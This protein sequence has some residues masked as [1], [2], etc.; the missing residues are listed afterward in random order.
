MTTPVQRII[1]AI[2]ELSK[3]NWNTI[4]KFI[5]NTLNNSLKPDAFENVQKI[6]ELRLTS[7]KLDEDIHSLNGN[8]FSFDDISLIARNNTCF[9]IIYT[10]KD[11]SEDFTELV[12]FRL[13]QEEFGN[14]VTLGIDLGKINSLDKQQSYTFKCSNFFI[15][16]DDAKPICG[17]KSLYFINEKIVDKNTGEIKNISKSSITSLR[18]KRDSSTYQGQ[19][20]RRFLPL[21]RITEDN[22]N[23]IFGISGNT[24]TESKEV[25][26]LRESIEKINDELNKIKDKNKIKFEKSDSLLGEWLE[27][28]YLFSLDKKELENVDDD[29]YKGIKLTLQ[30]YKSSIFELVQNIIFHGGK[31]GLIYCVFDKKAN[32]SNYYKGKLI[33]NIGEYENNARFLRIGIFDFN[34]NGIVKTYNKEGIKLIDFFDPKTIATTELSHLEMRYAAR[35]GIKTFVKTISNHKGF[36]SVESCNNVSEQNTKDRLYTTYKDEVIDFCEETIENTN[37]THYE[38]I[39][40]VIPSENTS[41]ENLPVQIKSSYNLIERIIKGLS[42]GIE[43]YHIQSIEIT[44]DDIKSINESK[45]KEDQIQRIQKVSNELIG[46]ITKGKTE[47]TID[48]D[49]LELENF[50]VNTIF[51]ILAYLQLAS[52]EG[53]EKIILINATDDFIDNFCGLIKNV[54]INANIE[55]IWSNKSAIILISKTLRTQIIYGETKKELCILNNEYHKYYYFDKTNYFN[56]IDTTKSTYIESVSDKFVLPYEILACTKDNV[57]YFESVITTILKRKIISDKQGYLVNHENTYIGSKII[58]K[59]YYEADT[60]FQ[61]SFFTERFAFLIAN[62]IKQKCLNSDANKNKKIVFIG[63]KYYSEYLIKAVKRLLPEATNIHTI[64]AN[65]EKDET[66]GIEK[67]VFN[68]DKIKDDTGVTIDES[69]INKPNDFLFI[70]VVPIGSTLST[71]DKIIAFFKLW[72]SQVSQEELRNDSFIYN[73][74]VIIVRDKLGK[75]LTKLERESK[76]DKINEAKKS[77]STTYQNVKE[78]FYTVSIAG[79]EGENNWKKRLNNEISF[80]NTWKEERYVNFTENSSINSQNLMGFPKVNICSDEQHY[81][82][83]DRLFEL[84]DDIYTGHIAVHNTDHKYYIDTETFVKRENKG[85]FGSWINEIKGKSFF[86]DDELNVLITPNTEIESDFISLINEKVFNKGA[87]IIYLDVNNWRNNIIHKL[88]FLKGLENVKYHYIDHALLTSETYKKTKSYMTSILDNEPKFFFKS[89]ICLIN[90]MSYSKNQEI[91][92]DVNGNLF[93]YVN[94]HY[95]ASKDPEQE[96]EM[97]KLKNYYEKKLKENTVLENCYE[98]IENNLKK[99][100]IIKLGDVFK[101]KKV[102]KGTDET[103]NTSEET[104]SKNVDNNEKREEPYKKNLT[105]ISNHKFIRLALTHELYYIISKKTLKEKDILDKNFQAIKKQLDSTYCQLC[106]ENTK[107]DKS[108]NQKINSWYYCELIENDELKDLKMYSNTKLQLDKRI[109]FLKVISSPPLSQYIIVRQ[110]AHEKLLEEL[111]EII[112]KSN[113]YDDIRL[114]KSILKSLSFLKS[115]ALVRKDVITNVWEVLF[116]VVRNLKGE[117]ER[118]KLKELDKKVSE[119]L[120]KLKNP[121]LFSIEENMEK[122]ILLKR[123]EQLIKK[124]IEWTEKTDIE[125]IEDFSKDFQ[126][127]IK[128]AIFD[129]EAK[130]MY[131]GELLRTGEEAKDFDNIIISETKLSLLHESAGNDLFE[132]NFPDIA[133]DSPPFKEFTKF[134]IWLFYDNTTIIRKTLNNFINELEKDKEIKHYFYNNE[135]LK[136]FSDV[137]NYITT[138]KNKFNNKVQEEYYYSSFKGYLDNGDSIDFVEK[139]IYVAYAKFKL[140]DLIEDQHKTDIET[141]TRDLLEV[142]TAIMGADAAFFAMR[143]EGV[144]YP[145]SLF[146]V[147]KGFTYKNKNEWNYKRWFLNDKLDNNY[148]YYT[149]EKMQ[150][151]EIKAPLIPKFDIPKISSTEI[152]YGEKR[153]LKADSLGVYLINDSNISQK[154]SIIDATITFL[155]NDDNENNKSETKFRINFQE[156]GRLLLLLKHEINKYVIDYLKK[157]KVLDLWV[158]KHINKIKFDKVY[159]RNNHTFKAV[160][161][162]MDIIEN[163]SKEDIQSLSLPW[164]NF[165]N[166]IVSYL[167]ANIHNNTPNKL[168]VT[169]DVLMMDCSIHEIFNDKFEALIMGLLNQKWNLDKD[170]DIYK[171]K[172]FINIPKEVNKNISVGINVHFIRSIIVQQ[173]NNCLSI[174]AGGHCITNET[175]EIHINVTNYSIEIKE[176]SIVGTIDKERIRM[177]EDFILKKRNI[178]NLNCQM[179]SSTTLTTL[180]G[181]INFLNNRSKDK[182]YNCNF[183]FDNDNKFNLLITFKNKKR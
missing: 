2:S 131:L 6:A 75:E 26:F 11:D 7:E 43:K 124:D 183:G 95:P 85:K 87:L 163:F 93:V 66:S 41:K 120:D 40:P 151:K 15:L 58:V 33:P 70:T 174:G 159:T 121:D 130:A 69:I 80:P 4:Y 148:Y 27:K 145:I 165:T 1:I 61:N 49:N 90:R 157:D 39:L 154:E 122:R 167:Y 96:C 98:V 60:L 34:E 44:V 138:I 129:D 136:P 171:H 20:S 180:Q 84:K 8:G 3:D 55:P 169:N 16:I 150:Y 113:S 50:E 115:N 91:T 100:E 117:E 63:Y 57:P 153:D 68:F 99:L 18:G 103:V 35:L 156:S 89:I 77:I 25:S 32:I 127:F 111:N 164:F 116:K 23:S 107:G 52:N 105:T 133:K 126:F 128:N 54:L 102:K 176:S 137:K 179:Y 17:Q 125:I 81:E 56:D 65:E 114:I 123:I 160:F 97:C 168:S 51:K 149:S 5:K 108:I 152:T 19:P 101:P 139:L 144:I 181:S 73:H 21:L 78:I 53:F 118:S 64:I 47:I 86:N 109:S 135:T 12:P 158:E 48:L 162:E 71:N 94:L 170:R 30:I 24:T 14:C 10:K 37:G 82:E 132:Y 22:F 45:G 88:S 79:N 67:I 74:C 31:N 104:G 134:L 112:G 141:D 140:K 59:N 29:T 173:L 46:K 76:W 166:Q 143:K 83:L 119:Q 38:I 110:Y 142:F 62:N 155:Y 13:M 42:G 177:K 28:G 161:V 36:F 146:D 9:S 182:E 172:V 92:A 178:I 175:K 106:K 147:I 72:F